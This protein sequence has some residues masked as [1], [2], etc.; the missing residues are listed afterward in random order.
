LNVYGQRSTPD[1]GYN[2]AFGGRTGLTLNGSARSDGG[3]IRLTG[4]HPFQAGSVFCTD[5]VDVRR[6]QTTFRFR[7]GN[8]AA[9]GFT[10]TIQGE[11]PRA[12]GG[13]GGGLGYG[14]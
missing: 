7:L 8:A 13:P 6:F 3:P 1:G 12:L 4:L 5:P 2:M 9:D 10:F 14:P 11:G